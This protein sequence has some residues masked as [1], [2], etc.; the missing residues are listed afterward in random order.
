MSAFCVRAYRP[1]MVVENGKSGHKKSPCDQNPDSK[2]VKVVTR[3]TYVTKTLARNGKSG[4][5][6]DLIHLR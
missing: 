5:K 4:H 3:S 2:W 6:K 1:K